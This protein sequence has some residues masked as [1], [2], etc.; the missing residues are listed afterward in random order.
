MNSN[1]I[2][3]V[4]GEGLGHALKRSLDG[5]EMFEEIAKDDVA[6]IPES[7]FVNRLLPVL[8]SDSGKQ[9]VTVWQEIAGT[10]MR[11]IVVLDDVGGKE[12]FRVPPLTRAVDPKV[13][14]R[15]RASAF[16]ILQTAKQKHEIMPA[17]GDEYIRANLARKLKQDPIRLED[18]KAWN[19]I[20]VRYGKEPLFPVEE[21]ETQ[22]S[23]ESQASADGASLFTGDWDDL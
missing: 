9:D 7:V 18:A 4:Y 5:I 6:R 21:A 15:G 14:G 10:T 11:A 20:L 8:T 22:T 19:A 3:A 12:L 1:D 13:T 2:D 23:A 17:L 16:E